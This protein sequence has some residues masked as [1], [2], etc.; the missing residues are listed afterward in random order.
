MSVGDGAQSD[1]FQ[2]IRKNVRV[3]VYWISSQACVVVKVITAVNPLVN[4]KADS[5]L[6]S[7]ISF[8]GVCLKNQPKATR[9]TAGNGPRVSRG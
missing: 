3:S 7:V 4:K 9:A 2:F 5:H 6:V 8:P 1:M